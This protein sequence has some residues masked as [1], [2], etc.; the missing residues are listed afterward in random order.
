M[1]NAIIKQKIPKWLRSMIAP[2]FWFIL[3]ALISATALIIWYCFSVSKI[4]PSATYDPWLIAYYLFTIFG[5]LGTF[6][7]VLVALAKESIMKWLYK[8]RLSVVLEEDGISELLGQDQKVPEAIAYRC[9]VSI[10]NNGSLAAMGCRVNI[11]DIKD[12]NGKK[13]KLIRNAI[14]KP[15]F[16]TA[17][18]VDIPVGIPTRLQLF[19]IKNPCSI[20]T[21][22]AT[23]T[24]VSPKIRFNGCT[25]NNNLRQKGK[26]LID[27]YISYTNG[28]A[29][30]FSVQIEWNGDFKSRAT[31]M[32]EA[33]DVKL[34]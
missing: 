21:P 29:F 28:D 22:N 10:E 30:K 24:T 1:N 3:G 6:L 9:Y 11:S 7:A 12:L 8:P 25:L 27:Y 13:P 33:L 32:K 18:R 17:Q 4:K 5:A 2:L 23:N 19:E 14:R 34:L 20:G 16:W 15:L 26:W 31:D